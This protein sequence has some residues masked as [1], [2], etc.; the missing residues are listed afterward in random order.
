MTDDP[1]LVPACEALLAKMATAAAW[2]AELM[3]EARSAEAE[4]RALR[5]AIGGVL[6]V[7]PPE[8]RAAG[9]ARLATAAAA[10]TGLATPRGR[11][12]SRMAAVHAVLLGQLGGRITNRD[13]SHAIAALGFPA[14]PATVARILHA[15]KLQGVVRPLARGL[16]EVAADHPLLTMSEPF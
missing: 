16:W 8:A 15:K 3:R 5:R 9:E 7:M 11:P 12:S 2:R 13:V 4:I 6:A 10:A 14:S 1:T